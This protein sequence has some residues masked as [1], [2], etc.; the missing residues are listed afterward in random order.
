MFNCIT[1]QI[2]QLIYFTDRERNIDMMN[3]E[4]KTHGKYLISAWDKD[5]EKLY[6]MTSNKSKI[7]NIH[8]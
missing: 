7:I 2:E 3:Y 4:W 1:S 5:N 6:V 8:I